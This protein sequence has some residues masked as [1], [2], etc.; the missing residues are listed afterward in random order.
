[1]PFWHIREEPIWISGLTGR[2]QKLSVLVA[3]V[4]LTGDKWQKYTA[5][6]SSEVPCIL[7]T[8]CLKRG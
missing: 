6:A 3:E 5:A 2:S 8:D 4:S 1:M 7:G